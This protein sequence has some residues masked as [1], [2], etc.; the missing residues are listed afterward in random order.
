MWTAIAAFTAAAALLVIAPGPDTLLVLRNTI[1]RG[2]RA[3]FATAAGTITG[4]LV[5]GAAAAL[6]LAA[7]L[8]ASRV[9]FTIVRAVGATYLIFLGLTMILARAHDRVERPDPEPTVV[10]SAP[11]GG[12]GASYLTGVATNLFNP[13]V[14]V[15][16]ISF[17]PV[18]VPRGAPV[19]PTSALFGAIFVLEGLLWLTTLVLV[20]GRLAALLTRRS[21]RPRIERV[22]GLFMIG[23]GVRLATSRR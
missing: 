1:R 22:A 17:L 6:G 20:G 11:S 21:V 15:F 16:F 18:F 5:W 3:G 13:K 19:G 8:R 14:G 9:G 7:L 23:F 4:L 12:V 10:D 2:R